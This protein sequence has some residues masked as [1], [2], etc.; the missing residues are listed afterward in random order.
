VRVTDQVKS[1]GNKSVLRWRLKPG[2]WTVHA[3]AHR[4]QNNGF[5]LVITSTMP[6]KRFELVEGWESR[7]YLK[8][9]PLPVLEIET[10]EPGELI[11]TIGWMAL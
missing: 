11:T 2:D 4:I 6:I 1:A 5:S 9:T 10:D 7:Y 3:D 8:K